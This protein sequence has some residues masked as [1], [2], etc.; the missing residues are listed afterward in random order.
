MGLLMF[1]GTECTHC[2]EMIPLIKKLEKETGVKVKQVETWH[3]SA[4]K[5]KL[6]SSKG[7]DKCGGVPFFLNE[8]TGKSLCGSVDYD[9][10]KKWA[11]K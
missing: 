6:E 7:Y 10:L 2:H 1:Y 9:K 11:G 4:N 5:K 8:E 3:N